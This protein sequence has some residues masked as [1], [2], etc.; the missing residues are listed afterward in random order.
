MKDKRDKKELTRLILT[1]LILGGGSLLGPVAE[2]DEPIILDATNTTLP[3]GLN[4]ED[5]GKT[6]WLDN[7]ALY[8]PFI[9]KGV[10]YTYPYDYRTYSFYG[11]KNVSSTG[12]TVKL[13]SG[14]VYNLS[15][16]FGA[17]SNDAT[18]NKVFIHSADA[19]T[20]SA[21]YKPV[22]VSNDGRRYHYPW[23]YEL[24]HWPDYA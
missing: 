19:A 12:S 6:I 21:T 15:G 2:A 1:A 22:H 3:N 13:F 4:H 17:G 9:I 11:G 14:Q 24:G 16:Y 10:P 8:R 5:G 18:G 7:S 23:R 20:Y